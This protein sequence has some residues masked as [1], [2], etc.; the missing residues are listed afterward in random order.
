MGWF[1]VV[2]QRDS[3]IDDAALQLIAAWEAYQ[4]RLLTR[5]GAKRE[6]VEQPMNGA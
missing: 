4:Q 2:L 5:M 1:L 6:S 3:M